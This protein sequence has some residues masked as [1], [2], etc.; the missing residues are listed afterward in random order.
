MSDHPTFADSIMRS[1]LASPATLAK[2]AAR[3]MFASVPLNMP[4]DIHSAN[5]EIRFEGE[6]TERSIIEVYAPGDDTGWAV[7]YKPSEAGLHTG[8]TE[9]IWG[10]W[11]LVREGH[12]FSRAASKA[13]REAGEIQL[14]DESSKFELTDREA[15]KESDTDMMPYEGAEVPLADDDGELSLADALGVLSGANEEFE[16]AE[17]E[18][19]KEAD[20]EAAAARPSGVFGLAHAS[21]GANEDY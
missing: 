19:D 14:V 2:L 10:K 21:F 4:Q 16:L 20:K 8:E 11:E 9:L 15:E 7:M 12:E 1:V 18:A 6:V 13:K 17:R 3:G 5:L